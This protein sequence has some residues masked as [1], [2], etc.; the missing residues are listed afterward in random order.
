MLRFPE[1]IRIDLRKM[2]ETL[3][4]SGPDDKL[5]LQNELQSIRESM[6]NETLKIAEGFHLYGQTVNGYYSKFPPF[7][8][9]NVQQDLEDFI[10]LI[11]HSVVIGNYFLISEWGVKYPLIQPS[12]LA[13][14]EHLDR[15]IASFRRAITDEWEENQD[16]FGWPDEAKSYWQYLI[17]EWEKWI[18]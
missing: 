11:G 2:L 12:V 10:E 18:S 9:G 7:S 3:R 4:Q 16:A 1:S 5:T 14:G 13:K 15:Y 17:E 6:E 8:T